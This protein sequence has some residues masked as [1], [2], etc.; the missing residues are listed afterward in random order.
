M[1]QPIQAVSFNGSWNI[2]QNGICRDGNVSSHG[3]FI[4]GLKQLAKDVIIPTPLVRWKKSVIDKPR[5]EQPPKVTTAVERVVLDSSREM[6]FSWIINK[7]ANSI[8]CRCWAIYDLICDHHCYEYNIIEMKRNAIGQTY[9]EK[10]KE[11]GPDKAMDRA[12]PL[13]FVFE[14]F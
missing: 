11:T 4:N 2:N 9:Q 7:L 8:Q 10:E 14:G 12:L 6:C 1:T 5:S 3:R 13:D